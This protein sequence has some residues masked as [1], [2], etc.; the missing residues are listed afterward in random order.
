MTGSKAEIW[1]TSSRQSMRGWREEG[2]SA[3]ATLYGC[4]LHQAM[5]VSEITV[6]HALV[7]SRIPGFDVG[8]QRS[9]ARSRLPVM[10]HRWSPCLKWASRKKRWTKSGHATAYTRIQMSLT[11]KM[12]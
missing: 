9:V 3:L 4:V 2:T 6:R 12:N 1:S 5:Q 10:S 8:S 11:Q 7:R